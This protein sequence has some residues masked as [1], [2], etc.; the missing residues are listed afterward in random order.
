L[1]DD[2][3]RAEA[4]NM[5]GGAGPFDF[6]S[7][8]ATIT[9]IPIIVKV[10]GLAAISDT[11]DLTAAVDK[12]AVTVDEWVTAFAAASIAGWTASKAV[13]TG[14]VKLVCATAGAYVQV[15]G[16]G[17]KLAM[18][19]QGKGL[20]AIKS[21]TIQT[22]SITPTVKADT[23]QT[24]TDANNKDTE[25]IIEGYK[26]GWTGTLVD[27][28]EDFEM[29]ELIE[30]GTLSTDGKTYTDPTSKTKKVMFEVESYN[31]YYAS[32]TNTEDQI[33]AWEHKTFRAAKGS[34]GDNS[35]AAGFGVKNY[36]LSGVNYKTGSGIEEGAIITESIDL[37]DWSTEIFDLI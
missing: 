4:A 18:F 3:T 13:T 22:L 1:N 10:N 15:Y 33:V 16:A 17:A 23:T 8:T 19:G 37:V 12:A 36:A 30:S 21:D 25:V 20:K 6:S 29:L 11:M 34:V 9:A 32:G 24:V 35:K 14:R 5:I 28:A 7:L 2:L 31:P 26:K 27:T